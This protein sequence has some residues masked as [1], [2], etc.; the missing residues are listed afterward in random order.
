MD[1]GVCDPGYLAVE[2]GSSARA[3]SARVLEVGPPR[4]GGRIRIQD[5][6]LLGQTGRNY[7]GYVFLYINIST[8]TFSS[9]VSHIDYHTLLVDR[10]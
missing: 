10:H 5:E 9:G 7:V 2:S 1:A 4:A 6:V 8:S 3:N